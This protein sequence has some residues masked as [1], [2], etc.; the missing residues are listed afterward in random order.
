MS[1]WPSASIHSYFKI[2]YEIYACSLGILAHVCYRSFLPLFSG[3]L[4]AVPG[5]AGQGH[6]DHGG[7]AEGPG[8]CVCAIGIWPGASPTRSIHYTQESSRYPPGPSLAH[9]PHQIST[10][11]GA[12]LAELGIFGSRILVGAKGPLSSPNLPWGNGKQ[13]GSSTESTHI[14][15]HHLGTRPHSPPP[16]PPR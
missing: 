7:G 9:R 6:R 10:Q 2:I 14:R 1:S 12:T 15:T 4:Y 13:I 3:R 8:V 11:L 16:P 5:Y